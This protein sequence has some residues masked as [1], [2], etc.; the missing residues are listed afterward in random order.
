[1][2]VRPLESVRIGGREIWPPFTIPSG[3]I[4]V[5]PDLIQRVAEEVPIGL[6]TAKSVGATPRDGYPEPVFSQYSPDSLSTAIGLSNPGYQA[7]VEEMREFYPIPGKFLLVS[8]FG[9]TPE[10]VVRGAEAV[11][12]YADGI[13]L[14][15]CCPHS[16]RYGEVLAHQGD[17]TVEITRKVRIHPLSPDVHATFAICSNAASTSTSPASSLYPEAKTS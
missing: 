2:P 17:L 14:N 6:I 10:E 3:I 9:E 1:M 13:E 11:A 4:T 15:F 12:P 7:W 8:G 5:T 16:L